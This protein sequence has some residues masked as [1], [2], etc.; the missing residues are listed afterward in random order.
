MSPLAMKVGGTKGDARTAEPYVIGAD[1]ATGPPR[2]QS[3]LGTND[4]VDE[5]LWRDI[6]DAD[7]QQ[8]D[9]QQPAAA[10]AIGLGHSHVPD[11][12]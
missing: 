5:S 10:K 1:P 11:R 9:E 4:K 7:R 6:H 3:P 12:S 2:G 8:D